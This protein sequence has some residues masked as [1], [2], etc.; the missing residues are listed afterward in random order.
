MA[1]FSFEA[2]DGQG[3]I[4]RDDVDATSQDEAVAKIRKLGF[5]PTSVKEKGRRGAPAVRTTREKKTFVIGGVSQRQLT[6]FTRQLATLQDAGLPLLRSVRILQA[7]LKPGVLKNVLIDVADDIEGGSTCSEAF[8]N[9]PRV[10]DKL[11]VNIVRAG[12]VGGVLDDMLN[13]L[14][15]F[16]EKSAK[17][18]KTVIAAL[19]YPAVVITFATLILTAIMI[20]VIPQFET[21]FAEFGLGLPPLTN[22]VLATARF[23]KRHFYVIPLAPI[24]IWLF[25]KLV[26]YTKTGRFAIDLAKLKLPLVGTIIGKA[27]ISRFTRTLGTLIASGV[28]IL[29]AL[30]IVKEATGNSVVAK[31]VGNVHDSIREGESMAEPLAQSHVADAMVVNMI[32]VGEETGELDKM[33][34]KV[35][36]SYDEDVEAAVNGLVSVLEP[37]LI[38]C[39]ACVVGTIVISLF[40]PLIKLMNSLGEQ[41]AGEFEEM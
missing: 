9:H 25:F 35:A 26:G 38:I 34:T 4:V 12:E 15:E 36:D 30:N 41:D 1:R 31:A 3:K 10:F 19:I 18:R 17:I 6:T 32:E 8:A 37:V 7:Q 5:F 14:A 2:M 23:L 20:F 28:P 22:G 39:M 40:L 27:T 24:G 11:F 21:M 16:R 29:E 33:L 13:R